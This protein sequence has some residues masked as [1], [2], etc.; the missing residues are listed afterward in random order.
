MREKFKEMDIKMNYSGITEMYVRGVEE[1]KGFSA[2]SG[3]MYA[4]TR[5]DIDLSTL[6]PTLTFLTKT[7]QG[8]T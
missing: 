6:T 5:L 7:S 8:A 3:M 1:L 4:I 2:K